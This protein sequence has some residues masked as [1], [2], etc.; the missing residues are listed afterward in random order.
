MYAMVAT[1]PDIAYAVSA[2]GQ[3]AHNPQEEHWIA[4]RHVLLYLR[5]SANIAL[6]FNREG[7]LSFIGYSDA[8]WGGNLPGRR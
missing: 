7:N 4:I 1:R 3:F 8:D 6:K 2:T 5:G